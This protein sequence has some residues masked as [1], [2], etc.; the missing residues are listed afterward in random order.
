MNYSQI[1][2]RIWKG[3]TGRKILEE[4]G[5]SGLLI[6]IYLF[7]S[8]HAN[9]AGVYSI[10]VAYIALETN[11]TNDEV[12]DILTGLER[13]GFIRYDYDAEVVWVI[14][15]VQFQV[16]E[17]PSGKSDNR[18]KGVVNCLKTLP[19]TYLTDAFRE[20]WGLHDKDN[21]TG[22]NRRNPSKPLANPF[23]TPSTSSPVIAPKKPSE[24]PHAA[25][26]LSPGKE[27]IV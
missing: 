8:P 12:E 4:L 20:Y 22:S 19:E 11:R 1:N 13:L 23:E 6:A 9:Q 5:D 21:T 25:N 27:A 10:P 3:G 17:F 2:P 15:M 7:S 14:K 16:S 18:Y 26:F 24:E